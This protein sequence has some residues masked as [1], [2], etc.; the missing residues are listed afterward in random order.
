MAS[1]GARPGHAGDRGEGRSRAAEA[2]PPWPR[3]PRRCHAWGRETSG[4]WR[5]HEAHDLLHGA[6]QRAPDHH[7]PLRPG[8]HRFQHPGAEGAL[9]GHHGPVR[10]LHRPDRGL[11]V[12]P[13]GHHRPDPPG[14][15][16]ALPHLSRLLL[17][18]ELDHVLC[19]PADLLSP[20]A[21]DSG[22]DRPHAIRVF[23]RE[24]NG[25]HALAHHQRCG[26][27][28]AEPE[29]GSRS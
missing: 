19:I 29:S 9:P 23:R 6:I 12:H 4:L 24:L 5:H 13:H 2:S 25:R 8:L 17:G 11:R 26:H 1:A 10:G 3:R 14:Y 16:W 20:E 18:A 27:L 22:E 21:G 28:G 7:L 15:S